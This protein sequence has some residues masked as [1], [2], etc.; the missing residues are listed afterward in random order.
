VELFVQT[1]TSLRH[2]WREDA[3]A[4]RTPLARV[5]AEGRVLLRAESAARLHA[6]KAQAR[7]EEGPKPASA[8]L[9][10]LRRYRLTD[11][12]DDLRGCPDGVELAYLAGGL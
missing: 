6:D 4:R 5:C 3:E 8:E 9:L 12:L 11:L 1:P 10:E 7:L 2:Y